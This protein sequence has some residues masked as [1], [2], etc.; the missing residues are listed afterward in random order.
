MWLFQ[1]E[2]LH[3]VCRGYPTVSVAWAWSYPCGVGSH[4]EPG[5]SPW[6]PCLCLQPEVGRWAIDLDVTWTAVTPGASSAGAPKCPVLPSLSAEKPGIFS[7]ELTD[8]TVIEGEDLTL[9]CETVASDSPVRWTK[10][11][12]ALRPS[13]R[14][15]LS[16]EGHRAQLVIT[17]T[18]LQ[19]GGR[20]KC[21][22]GGVW[23]SSIIRVHG[24][25]PGRARQPPAILRVPTALILLRAK[26]TPDPI[27]LPLS[28]SVFSLCVGVGGVFIPLCSSLSLH[29]LSLSLLLTHLWVSTADRA[30]L[31]LC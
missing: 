8:A 18:T 13:A 25:S 5:L 17:D 2:L 20:Y 24:E 11:G 7:R 30:T 1:D 31:A 19:D 27:L 6:Q 9:V 21:E 28:M 16:R 4:T 15:Q 10:D 23:S 22:A 14:C 12:K 26:K 3:L 29:S